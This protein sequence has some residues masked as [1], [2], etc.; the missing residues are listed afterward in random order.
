MFILTWLTSVS[1]V[2]IIIIV[3]NDLTLM[4]IVGFRDP[5]GIKI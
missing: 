4:G 5:K 1:V 2:L 3:T